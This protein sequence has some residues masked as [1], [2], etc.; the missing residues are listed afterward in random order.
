MLPQGG[1]PSLAGKVLPHA[2]ASPGEVSH[3]FSGPLQ[4]LLGKPHTSESC[5]AFAAQPP[6]PDTTAFPTPWDLAL[7]LAPSDCEGP[8]LGDPELGGENAK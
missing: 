6:A 8:G 4:K 5:P 1:P 2:A 7:P 3:Q